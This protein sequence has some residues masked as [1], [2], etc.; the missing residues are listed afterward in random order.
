[1]SDEIAI[2]IDLGTSNSCV[3]VSQGKKVDV[4]R[5][6]YGEATTACVVAFREDGS[7]VVG[8]A[9]KAHLI[10]D[11]HHTVSSAKRLIGRY[12]F[13]DEV[14][15]ARLMCSYKI[16]DAENHGLRIGIRDEEFAVPEI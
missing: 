14:K 8:N 3:A 12:S 6:S 10:H 5:N 16:T 15:K 2:G 11:P 13:S 4:L 9:A 7:I 1:M